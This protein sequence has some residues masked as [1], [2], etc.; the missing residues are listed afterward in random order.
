MSVHRI[1]AQPP[2]NTFNFWAEYEFEVWTFDLAFTSQMQFKVTAEDRGTES[3]LDCAMDDFQVRALIPTAEAVS[4]PA[5]TRPVSYVLHPSQPN[6]FNPS[7]QIR[8]ELP[9]G[10]RVRLSIYDVTGRELRVLVD[11]VKEAGTHTASWDGT[12]RNGQALASGVYFYRLEAGDFS[13]THR[14]TLLK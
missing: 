11:E 10:D 9:Q 3:L 4:R 13:R 12:D 2:P 14:M 6:P 7:T 8:Y 1:N 5:A